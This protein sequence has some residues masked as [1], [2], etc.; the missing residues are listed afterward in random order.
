MAIDQARENNSGK[1]LVPSDRQEVVILTE[2]HTL[3]C[4]CPF[5]QPFI[6][7]TATPVFLRCQHVNPPPSHASGDCRVDVDIHI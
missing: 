4:R 5:Q 2:Q 3:Q 1:L 7:K 6:S